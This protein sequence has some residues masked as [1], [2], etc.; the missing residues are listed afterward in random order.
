MMNVKFL[1]NHHS[2]SNSIGEELKHLIDKAKN[3]F[4]IISPY[5]SSNPFLIL[6]ELYNHSNQSIT[7]LYLGISQDDIDDVYRL[8]EL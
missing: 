7:K 3:E 6:M 5:I 2:I 8:A 4:M 1:Y